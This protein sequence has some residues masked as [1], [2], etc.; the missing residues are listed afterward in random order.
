MVMKTSPH[1]L[2]VESV[3]QEVL[4]SD[5]N[6]SE[7]PSGEERKTKIGRETFRCVISADKR[8]AK[9][10]HEGSH[11]SW[12]FSGEEERAK[13]SEW[14]SGIKSTCSLCCLLCLLS[15]VEI[16]NFNGACCEPASQPAQ[17]ALVAAQLQ[18]L[19]LL[20]PVVLLRLL[21][22]RLNFETQQ[23]NR[24][25][26]SSPSA[27]PFAKFHLEIDARTQPFRC[28]QHTPRSVCHSSET[29]DNQRTQTQ[30]LFGLEIDVN[31]GLTGHHT[32]LLVTISALPHHPHLSFHLSPH[33]SQT[34]AQGLLGIVASD[35]QPVVSISSTVLDHCFP[36][37]TSCLRDSAPEDVLR[38]GS[39]ILDVIGYR[40]RT[41]IASH[42]A[43]A[44]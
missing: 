42:I 19:S 44:C 37:T 17:V 11:P 34:S 31:F 16:W 2:E 13:K 26:R 32:L 22:A 4:R 43:A 7:E 20:S 24:V 6:V 5:E 25:A 40:T 27:A 39:H 36:W 30:G 29:C 1:E 33:Q 41:A 28:L 35:L 23:I 38:G 14:K 21:W 12:P 10:V 9:S 3:N 15:C 18:P 8:T